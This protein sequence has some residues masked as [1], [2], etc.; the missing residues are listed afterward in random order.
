MTSTQQ[1]EPQKDTASPAVTE[2]TSPAESGS[3]HLGRAVGSIARRLDPAN[4]TLSTGE[5]AELRRISPEKPFTPTLWR[6]LYE[7]D[8]GD[9]PGWIRQAEWER[10]WATLLMC[11]AHCPGLHDCDVPLGRGLAKAGWS[12]LRFTRLLRA[13]GDGL[14][15]DLR[16]VAQYLKNKP[17]AIDWTDIAQLLFYQSGETG[18]GIRLSIARTYYRT[19]YTQE[20]E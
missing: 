3:L 14:E 6:I 8:R 7:L 11:M 19:L 5:R 4:E 10:R 15:T 1:L 2:E 16:R 13:E 9:A 20:Q 17:Q 12:E 18:E